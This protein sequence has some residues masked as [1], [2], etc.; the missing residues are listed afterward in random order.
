M[1]DIFVAPNENLKT[2]TEDLHKRVPEDN[3][4][5]ENLNLEKE[6]DKAIELEPVEVQNEMIRQPSKEEK[7]NIHTSLDSTNSYS[8]SSVPLFTSYWR[9]PKGVYFE[10]QEP[11]EDIIIFLRKHFLTNFNWLASV[12]IL[13][14][15]PIVVFSLIT[16]F[17]YSMNFLPTGFIEVFTATYYL[18][19]IS[20]GFNR[21]LDWYYNIALITKERIFDVELSN[22][23]SKTVVATKL[24]L[25]QDV[26]N[27]QTGTMRSLF[28]YGDVLIQTAGAQD[29]F[30][31]H[32]VPKPESVVDIVENLIGKRNREE[33]NV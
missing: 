8:N 21:F 12:I 5:L 14:I 30:L 15:I 13:L 27:K 10:T 22:L 24:S 18:F 29:N 28:N 20:Y 16:Y 33:E 26:K 1:P 2:K 4:S 7:L 9:N 23:V 25:V 3:T 32:A 17:R 31:M 11:N 6:E 19:I